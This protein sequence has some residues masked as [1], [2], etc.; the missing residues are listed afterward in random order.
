VV[1]WKN[2]ELFVDSKIDA[3]NAEQVYQQGLALLQQASYPVVVNLAEMQH[4][5]TLALAVLIRWLKQS[6]DAHALHFKAA[7]IKML[8]II[9]ACHL[10]HDLKLI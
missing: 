8:K 5:S 7:P 6:P 2:Q 3:D 4:G 10:E 1:A 9:Q